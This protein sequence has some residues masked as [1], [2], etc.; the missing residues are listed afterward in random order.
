MF[1]HII[2]ILTVLFFVHT[3]VPAWTASPNLIRDAEVE[4]TIRS[5]AT[6]LFR[7]AGLNAQDVEIYI[8]NDEALNAFVAGV[9]TIGVIFGAYMGE[10]FRGAFQAVEDSENEDY[11]VVSLSFRPQTAFSGNPGQ[12]QFFIEKEGTVAHRQVLSALGRGRRFPVLPV[13]IGLVI[14]GL[15]IALAVVVA[16]GRCSEGGGMAAVAAP[17]ENPV[18]PFVRSGLAFF[19]E[20]LASYGIGPEVGSNPK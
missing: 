15:I 9:V 20:V 2:F 10:T 3:T 5:Y 11:Y 12:E 8:V 14:V 7:A 19:C 13:A 16:V 17:P 18:G 4:A 6:P 1:R